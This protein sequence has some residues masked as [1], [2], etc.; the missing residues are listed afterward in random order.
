MKIKLLKKFRKRFDIIHF[1]KGIRVGNDFYDYNVFRLTDKENEYW[2]V[3]CQLNQEVYGTPKT[4]KVR[5]P[6]CPDS[7]NSE[8]ECINILI[9]RMLFELRSEYSQLGSKGHSR[10]PSTKVWYNTK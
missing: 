9:E 7:A 10:I 5:I 1:P 6:F 2:R 8:K 4:D 3:Y